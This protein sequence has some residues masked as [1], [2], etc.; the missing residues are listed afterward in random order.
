MFTHQWALNG[1][2]CSAAM[3]EEMH[4]AVDNVCAVN[5]QLGGC[6]DT[7]PVNLI[8]IYS[9]AMGVLTDLW[10]ELADLVAAQCAEGKR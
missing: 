3:L 6:G 9:H 2:I 1:R 7:L 8:D 5:E 10:W 4:K